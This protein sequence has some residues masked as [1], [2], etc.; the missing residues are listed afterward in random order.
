[1]ADEELSR[2]QRSTVYV[3]DC[4]IQ[5][6]RSEFRAVDNEARCQADFGQTV[7]VDR[8]CTRKPRLFKELTFEK[9]EATAED[10]IVILR[11]PVGTRAADLAID[12]ETHISFHA[13]VL[14]SAM[15]GFR[16]DCLGK[17]LSIQ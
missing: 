14:L 9:V 17:I 11:T 2:P 10:V 8:P 3:F 6:I 7:D 16:P 5:N 13:N 4:D 12:A 15:G 1:V